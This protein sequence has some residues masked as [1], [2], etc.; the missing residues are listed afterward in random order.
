MFD[1]NGIIVLNKPTGMSS[2]LAVQI[3]KRTLRPNKIGHLGT[4]DPL[5]TGM[6]MLALNKST[7]LFDEY[8]KK[9][10]TYK[11]IFYFGKET[12]TLDSEGPVINKNSLNVTL[13]QVKEVAKLFVGEF[14]QMPPLY[15]AKKINGKKAYE[16]VRLGK[17]VELK[18]RRVT[19]YK[20]DVLY[21]VAP[22]T[23]MFEIY[24][25][26]GTYIRSICRDIAYKLSTYGTML[27]IIR[28][29]C[30]DYT[31]SDSCTLEDIKSGNFKFFEQ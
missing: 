5:G 7:K 1:K 15:S 25:S 17:Q 21:E 29:T 14:D 28:T 4:L 2:S 30:G 16:L 13:E 23:F 27:S 12:D 11:A 31:I 18:T 10:K 26:S 22:N 3:V 8:L 20:C 19:I 6:L 24:C 9:N